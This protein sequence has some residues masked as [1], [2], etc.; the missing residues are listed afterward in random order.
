MQGVGVLALGYLPPSMIAIGG[1]W[2]QVRP[3]G[4][5]SVLNSI[6]RYGADRMVGCCVSC[7]IRPT[8][9]RQPSAKG[10]AVAC[11]IHLQVGTDGTKGVIERLREAVIQPE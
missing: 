7:H 11:A 6:Y 9:F 2:I 5:I 1:A 3:T 4:I 10:I 8:G